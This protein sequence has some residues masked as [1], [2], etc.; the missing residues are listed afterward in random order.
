MMSTTKKNILFVHYLEGVGGGERYLINVINSLTDNYNVFLLTPNPNTDLEKQITRPIIKISKRFIR[1]LGP[2]P[3]FSFSLFFVLKKLIKQND[4]E[5]VHLNDHYLLPACLFLKTKIIFTS[6]GFCDVYFWISRQVL[7][8]INPIVIT[9]TPVQYFRIHSLV[10][11]S[12]LMPFFNYVQPQYVSRNIPTTTNLGLVG[13]FSPVKNHF[14]AFEVVD[15]LNSLT[16]FSC[17]LN[18]YGG[19]VLK[20]SEENEGYE[21]AILEKINK[22]SN[23]LSHGVVNCLDE[24]YKNIDILLVTSDSESFSM[25]TIEAFSYGVPVVSTLTEGATSLIDEG[26][27]GFICRNLEEFV[28]KI[29]TIK[30]D[31]SRFSKNAYNSSSKY[32]RTNYMTSLER[33]YQ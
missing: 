21:N 3:A 25:V 9:A 8:I 26:V 12:F 24:I 7:K 32:D 10:D 11:K 18:I 15:Y 13:R 16:D 4:I 29:C 27:N 5:I 28:E 2:F 19:R 22:N 23:L 1:N 20:L 6:H 30:K 14:M 17:V 33:I 31:Y